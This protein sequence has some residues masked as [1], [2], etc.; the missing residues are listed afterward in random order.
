MA[1]LAQHLVTGLA[2][3]GIYALL[4]LGIVLVHRSSGVLNVAQ[5]E[6]ATLSA[7]VCFALTD[8]GWSFWTAF[9]AT[10][11]LS[12]AGGAVLYLALVRPAGDAGVLV[13]A[14]VLLAVGGLDAWIWGDAPR[15]LPKAFSTAEVHV[16]GASF[17]RLDLGVVAVALAAA[18]VAHFLYSRTRVGLALRAVAASTSEARAAGVPVRTTVATSFGIAATLGAVA[19]IL[20]AELQP[21]DP[22]LL[23]VALLY[24]VAAAA[25]GAF[26]S[27]ALAVVGGL[28]LGVGLDLLGA[29]AHL[30][31]ELKPA[32]AL[33][34][35]A[36]ALRGRRP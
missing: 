14:G 13:A 34:V 22:G 4:A 16:A 3:G 32:V 36:V 10:L 15:A 12:F 21:L 7:F 26:A 27:P 33:A 30:P 9:G 35:V 18:T 23:R 31:H 19:G 1:G 25:I 17:E 5:A 20:A 11:L 24:A 8:R 29:Y 6:L 28:A 2:A